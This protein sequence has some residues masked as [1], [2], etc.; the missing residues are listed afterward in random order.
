MY[1][2]IWYGSCLR[3]INRKWPYM[4]KKRHLAAIDDILDETFEQFQAMR[5]QL[6][7]NA[8]PTDYFKD[9]VIRS[10]YIQPSGEYWIQEPITPDERKASKST[11]PGNT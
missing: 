8:P 11:P 9:M 5:K 2:P 6:L 3:W 7:K 10:G 1:I 4:T